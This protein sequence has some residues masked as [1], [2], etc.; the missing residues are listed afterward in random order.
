MDR[1]RYRLFQLRQNVASSPLCM[2]LCNSDRQGAETAGVTNRRRCCTVARLSRQRGSGH[3]GRIGQWFGGVLYRAVIEEFP[4]LVSKV[5][6]VSSGR[7]KQE[8][9]EAS[10][11]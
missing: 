2:Q 4:D 5:S 8:A 11:D 9:L 7:E 1:P 3:F 6:E 10:K